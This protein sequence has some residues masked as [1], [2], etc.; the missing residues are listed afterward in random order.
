M[1]Q[2]VATLFDLDGGVFARCAPQSAESSVEPTAERLEALALEDRDPAS[3][4]SGL[5]CSTCGPGAALAFASLE[6]Q[7][8]HFRADWHRFNLKRR[9]VGLG[10]VTEDGFDAMLGEGSGEELGSISGS[11]SDDSSDDGGERARGGPAGPSETSAANSRYFTF[12]DPGQWVPW[13]RSGRACVRAWRIAWI[14]ACRQGLSARI[15]CPGR[16]DLDW[17]G[18]SSSATQCRAH[19]APGSF[20]LATTAA[21]QHTRS[22]PP[23][24]SVG[25]TDEGTLYGVWRSVLPCPTAASAGERWAGL[26]ELRARGATWAVLMLSGGHFA[27]AVLRVDP[28]RVADRTQADKFEVVVHGSAHRYVVRWACVCCSPCC[29]AGGWEG[30]AAWAWVPP[31]GV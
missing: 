20:P 29:V 15:D 18:R 19:T 27:A 21:G 25:C 30:K 6:A 5:T 13:E 3:E 24:P 1:A 17:R 22:S 2:A 9:L 4:E 28:R 14:R 16:G 12:R 8:A 10:P 26:A 11:A 7:R 31:R 23:A